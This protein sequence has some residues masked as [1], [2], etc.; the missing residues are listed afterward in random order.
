MSNTHRM[1]CMSHSPNLRSE[2]CGTNLDR[3]RVLARGREKV[4]AA[5]KALEEADLD[6]WNLAE[7]DEQT[8]LNFL[9]EHPY[10]SLVA[11]DERGREF[12]LP[13]TPPQVEDAR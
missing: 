6:S 11:V 12:P 4:V 10:C 1:V 5:L 9:R 2:E 7:R 8:V 3:I 13:G